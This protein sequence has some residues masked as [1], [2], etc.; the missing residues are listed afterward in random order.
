MRPSFSISS[1]APPTT[2]SPRLTPVSDGKPLR[3]LLVT[4]KAHVVFIDRFHGTPP[5]VVDG[6]VLLISMVVR[7]GHDPPAFA[8]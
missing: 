4:V 8:L 5:L 2:R 3:R 6:L 7:G 1:F